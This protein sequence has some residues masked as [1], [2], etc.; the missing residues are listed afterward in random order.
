MF[1]Y[2]RLPAPSGT[3]GQLGGTVQSSPP[4]KEAG[5]RP[6]RN[7]EVAYNVVIVHPAEQVAEV[8]VGPVYSVDIEDVRYGLSIANVASPRCVGM[9][10]E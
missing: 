3:L 10:Y 6:M 4:A 8:A 1:T 2:T 5:A 9:G 7:G